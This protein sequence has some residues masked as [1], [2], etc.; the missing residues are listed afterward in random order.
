MKFLA[1]SPS[2]SKVVDPSLKEFLLK[3]PIKDRNES[4]VYRL[5]QIRNNMKIASI[6]GNNWYFN[7]LL[8]EEEE[9]KR[10]MFRP[11]SWEESGEAYIRTGYIP[12]LDES[13]KLLKDKEEG[14]EYGYSLPKPRPYPYAKPLQFKP[15]EYQTKAVELLLQHRHATVESA[16][17]TGKTLIIIMLAQKLGLKTLVITPFVSI[18]EQMLK[19]FEYYFGKSAV[20]TYGGGKKKNPNANFIVAVSDSIA[21]V[22]KDHPDY[23]YF[24]R[25]EVAIFDEAHTLSAETLEAMAFVPLEHVPY[26]YFLTGTHTRPDGLNRLLEAITGPVVMR[27]KTKDAVADGYICPFKV[28]VVD[29]ESSFEGYV[30]TKDAMAIKRAHFLY[31][32]N[33]AKLIAETVYHNIIKDDKKRSALVLVSETRQV[34]LLYHALN[35]IMS[36]SNK[37]VFD[38][39]AVA[40]ATTNKESVVRAMMP[41]ETRKRLSRKKGSALISIVKDSNLLSEE[42]WK[43]I[44]FVEKS[45]IESA[46]EDFNLGKKRVLIGTT[47]ISTGVNIF[48]THFTFNWQGG[49][50]EIAC[51]QGAIGRSVRRLELSKY[52]DY[53]DP[54]PFSLIVDFNVLNQPVLYSMLKKR[55]QYYEE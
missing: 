36:G 1:V 11:I 14:I 44:D 35:S 3:S 50:S 8:K 26:R 46:V 31:N 40:T 10:A 30:N 41:D 12:Y 54:K 6:N 48:P 52:K 15:Y 5:G 53:H 38:V 16:T 29:V 18:F 51:K 27:Y 20:G 32:Y 7:K 42:E 28:K 45:D 23:E 49:S 34:Y 39:L 33:I 55:L 17:G 25:F 4:V 21:N 19:E 22:D 43:F 47:A 13:I 2:I 37:S 24:K 9:L